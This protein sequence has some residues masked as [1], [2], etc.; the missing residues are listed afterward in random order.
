MTGQT[1]EQVVAA[2]LQQAGRAVERGAELAPDALAL[3]GTYLQ[4]KAII[5]LMTAGAVSVMCGL[6]LIGLHVI[7]KKIAEAWS[8][9][10]DDGYFVLLVPVGGA[11]IL[12]FFV[13][14]V[15][16]KQL[17]NSSTWVRAVDGRLAVTSYVVDNL[18]R[19]N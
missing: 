6:S 10:R 7:F 16:I 5:D 13:G 12:F 2:L 18:G 4:T 3:A 15:H 1:L 9:D 17:T 11:A 14:L 8:R 19:R